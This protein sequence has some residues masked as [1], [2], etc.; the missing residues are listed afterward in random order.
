MI[1]IPG[2]YKSVKTN[3]YWK[4]ISVENGRLKM[5]QMVEGVS[6]VEVSVGDFE[7]AVKK[8]DMVIN[9]G[10]SSLLKAFNNIK[11]KHK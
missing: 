6:I 11:S 9:Y 8:G 3:S 7:D 10:L 4:T 5:I 1:C 2:L